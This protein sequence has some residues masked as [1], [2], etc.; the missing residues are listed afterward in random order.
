MPLS[1]QQQ[2]KMQQR[3]ENILEAATK[4]FA[5]EGYEGTTIKKVSQAAGVSFGSVFTYFKDKEELFNTCVLEPLENL[6]NHVLDF[7]PEVENPISELE[8]MVKKHIVFFSGMNEYLA[9]IVQV[10]GQFQKHI[11][12]F[13]QLDRFHDEFR[14]KVGQLI[15]NGQ[16]KNLLVEQDPLTVATLYISLL[17]G[18]RL[19]STDRRYDA[20]WEAYVP[21]TMHL[22]GPIKK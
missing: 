19:N 11:E 6:S 7:N 2:I 18:I 13:E 1:E 16:E 14:K 4:L 9:L 10:V 8:E 15:Q 5:T 3:R 21:S 17:I 12:T 22:F 20:I